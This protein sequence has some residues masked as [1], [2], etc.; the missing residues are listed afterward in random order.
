ML[1]PRSRG[2]SNGRRR[3]LSLFILLVS[4]ALIAG[5][6]GGGAEQEADS[7]G[8]TPG[9]DETAEAATGDEQDDSGG[10]AT[11]PVNVD[12]YPGELGDNLGAAFIETYDGEV[13]VVGNWDN[14]RFTEMQANR[15]N[16]VSDVAMFISPLTPVV[17][18]SE[19]TTA[20]DEAEIPNL[21]NVDPAVRT[22]GD[23]YVPVTYGT[24]GIMYNSEQVEEP[25]TSWGDL[26]RDDLQGHVSSPNITYN[27]SLYT[28]DALAQLEGGSLQGD[29]T[30]GYE[31]YRRIR[32]SGPGLWDSEST[33]V[34]W[35]K[36]GEVWATP[37]F[38]GNVLQLRE[39]DPELEHLEFVVPEEGGYYVPFNVF[40]VKDSPNPEA[41][42]AF[43][44]NML[45]EEAQRAWVESGRARPVN[46]NVDVPSE[47]EQTV[48]HV[49]ELLNLDWAYFAENRD[50]IVND[51][52]SQVN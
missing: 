13:N 47:I 38:S 32:E 9:D 5:A 31:A 44:N 6:C 8:P 4:L 45:G 46:T 49:D 39:D 51:F 20:L 7:G 52:N 41:A 43:I 34:G 42:T 24:W 14:P 30:P 33:A 1:S 25:I 18:E 3:S 22:E 23:P 11:G 12:W 48:P 15:D 37:F 16:P 10:Q 36:T 29:L 26:L 2:S 35:M 28:L 27:S 21:Q 17:V 19:L 50:R 40:Q